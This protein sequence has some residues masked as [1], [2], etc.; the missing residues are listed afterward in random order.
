M[1]EAPP[2]ESYSR[3]SQRPPPLRGSKSCDPAPMNRIAQNT[4]IAVGGLA[5]ASS[6]VSL[7][8]PGL[9]AAHPQR[10]TF[11]NDTYTTPNGMLEVEAGANVQF[12]KNTSVPVLMKYG[13]GERTEFF[14]G[15]DVAKAVEL[16]DGHSTTGIGDAVVGFRHRLRD[17]DE[18]EP[19]FAMQFFTKLP[20]ASQERGIGTGE[21]DFHTAVIVEKDFKGNAFV[22]F[23]DFGL[24]G[25]EFE[26][27][28]D[29]EHLFAASGTTP[30]REDLDGYGEVAF[31]WV[32]EQSVESLTVAGG[33]YYAVHPAFVLDLGLRVG[34]TDDAPDYQI[35]FGLTRALG[36][37]GLRR[38]VK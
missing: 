8:S 9:A 4:F 1:S 25:E 28:L 30:I 7:D 12:R 6:C 21:I 3:A 37:L 26:P 14:A 34:L 15:G 33:F 24:L 11:S 19:G 10:P 20:T 38:D 35:L 18:Y 27:E 13:M 32:P 2:S 17:K 36:K 31:D 23:Y 22:G 5:L 29:V 16:P